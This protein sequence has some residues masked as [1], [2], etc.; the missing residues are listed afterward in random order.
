MPTSNT[1]FGG[2]LHNKSDDPKHNLRLCVFFSK[3][4]NIPLGCLGVRSQPILFSGV[5]GQRVTKRTFD[6][7]MTKAELLLSPKKQLVSTLHHSRKEKTSFPCSA[8][9]KVKSK[10]GLLFFYEPEKKSKPFLLRFS[11][12]LFLFVKGLVRHRRGKNRCP[13]IKCQASDPSRGRKIVTIFSF[14]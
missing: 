4:P 10:K 9:L 8:L 2:L 6:Y 1:P 3:H 13:D 11:N 7:E 12:T 14:R 5:K